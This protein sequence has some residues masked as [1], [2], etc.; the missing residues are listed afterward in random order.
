M[1]RLETQWYFFGI[2]WRFGFSISQ[3]IAVQ[4]IRL[5]VI[6]F[7][8]PI[9]IIAVIRWSIIHFMFRVVPGTIRHPIVWLYVSLDGRIYRTAVEDHW[10]KRPPFYIVPELY[11]SVNVSFGRVT[12]HDEG[13]VHTP[14]FTECSANPNGFSSLP[15]KLGEMTRSVLKGIF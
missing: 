6:H 11:F 4:V 1:A 3:D 14:L 5:C 15:H 12:R 7:S 2:I 9:H 10:I 13:T 8:I